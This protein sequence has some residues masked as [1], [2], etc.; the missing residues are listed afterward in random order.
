MAAGD[1]GWEGGGVGCVAFH[2]AVWGADRVVGVCWAD[3]AREEGG[4][5]YC[6]GC[7]V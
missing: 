3:A 7:G 4:G 6:A 1:G 2:A 5:G